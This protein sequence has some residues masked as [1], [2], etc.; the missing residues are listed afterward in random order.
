MQINPSE[1]LTDFRANSG[2]PAAGENASKLH[3]D[4]IAEVIANILSLDDRALVKDVTVWATNPK[5]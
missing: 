2:R 5:D 1:V 3:A 4:D